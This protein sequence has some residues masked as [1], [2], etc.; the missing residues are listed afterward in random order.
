MTRPYS[1]AII[2]VSGYGKIYLERLRHHADV[3]DLKIVAAAILNQSDEAAACEKLKTYGCRLYDD[4][5]TMLADQRGCLDLV[6]I[7][8]GI[9]WHTR[10]T[11]AALEA[12]ANVLVEKPLA[13]T[14]REIEEIQCARERS[15]RFVAVGFQQMYADVTHQV[16]AR[17]ESGEIGRLRTVSGLG[18]WPRSP[19]YFSRNDWS[20]RVQVGGVPVWDSPLTNGLSHYLMLSLF[21]SRTGTN[22][23]IAHVEAELYRAQAIESYDTAAIRLIMDTG[24]EL[25]FFATHSCRITL[26]PVLVLEG[27]EGRIVWTTDSCTLRRNDGSHL[28]LRVPDETE[29]R[30]QMFDCV[31]R[32]LQDV[33]EPICTPELAALHTRCVS[34]FHHAEGIHDIPPASLRHEP[35]LG[36]VAGQIH[37]AGIEDALFRAFVEHRLPAEIGIPWSRPAFV[38]E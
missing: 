35:A 15:G 26:D 34:A 22:D 8:T 30:R 11:V 6:L 13:M 32:R 3:G 27:S 18:L 19:A 37:I 12:G 17:I 10:M 24:V 1:T 2:G 31:I 23:A 16:R 7:P 29:A 38:P 21:W 33:A 9:P 14:I 20:G 4:F 25:L 36:A 5:I 28:T